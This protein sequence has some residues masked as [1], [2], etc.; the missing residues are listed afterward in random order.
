MEQLLGLGSL[1]SL[2]FVLIVAVFAGLVKGV[3][4]FAMPMILISGLTLVI[5]PEQALAALILP[6]LLTN[7]WQAFRQGIK[8]AVR[9]VVEFRWFLLSG[10]VLLVLSAQ[11]VRVLDPR[12]LYGLIGGPVALFSIMQLA[13]WKPKLGAR[14]V[15]LDTAIGS[16]AGFI[17]GL[18]GV[19][20][21][22]T[23]AY[24]TATN[25]PKQDQMRAQGVIYGLGAVALAGAHLQT[26][27]LRAE[28]LPLTLV[29]LPCALLGLWLGFRV[30][31]RIP[32][33]VFRRATLV[34][35]TIAGLNLLRRAVLG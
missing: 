8:S 7:T 5:P 32:Q 35:L 24:L 21:P 9:S 34:V 13:G 4:G 10:L 23:V 20:G 15:R 2:V 1:L 22:P 27:V 12:V 11:L 31:D 17:G 26:G 14:T 29:I 25:I 3:V 19:W 33:V 28:T 16:F 18:S 6:T 30:Q